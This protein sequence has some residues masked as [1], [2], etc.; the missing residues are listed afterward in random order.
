MRQF[1]E[2]E[3]IL[4]TGPFAGRPFRVSRQPWTGLWFDAIDSRRWRRH[5]LTSAQQASKTLTGST[6]PVTYHLFERQED[7]IYGIPDINMASDKWN[8]D[9][10]PSIES[11]R[12]RELLPKSGRGSKG[13]T[14]TSIQFANGRSL[15]FMVGG[16][17]DKQRAG[18]TS[19][20]LVVT[21]ADGFDVVGATSRESDKFEQLEGRLR[22][23]GDMATL[24]A[25]C[26]LSTEDG[27]TNR[28]IKGGTNSRILIRCP[29]CRAW[30]TPERQHLVGWQNAADVLQAKDEARIACPDCGELW[31]E[32]DRRTANQECTL[33]HEGQKLVGGEIQGNPK[34]TDTLGFRSTAVNNF[35]VTQGDVAAEEL[36]AS[37]DPDAERGDK[38]M[39]QFF[40]AMPAKNKNSA[41]NN[42][43][44]A[45]L[46]MRTAEWKRD[47]VPPDASSITLGIDVGLH[48]CHW[49]AIAWLPQATP[50]VLAY[51]IITHEVDGQSDER[52]I[53][54]MLR[55]FRD[56][57]A[58]RGWER[59]ERTILPSM[60]LVDSG[61]KTETVY[62]FIAESGIPFYPA[63]G[64]GQRQVAKQKDFIT[65][66]MFK[67]VMLDNGIQLVDVNA[68]EAKIF[69]HARLKTDLR[70][71]DGKPNAGA[72]T[73][74]QPSA[75]QDHRTWTHHV[76]AEQ[77][78]QE[79]IPGK[80]TVRKLVPIRE[81]NHYLDA[82]ALA[83]VAGVANGQRVV[84][85]V[86]DPTPKPAAKERPGYIP[87]RPNNYLNR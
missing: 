52:A 14:P 67:P 10:K 47:V 9:I 16:G 27:R 78:E 84:T 6:V 46:M 25:E 71:K 75:G 86:I 68:D 49:T 8:D 54:T 70:D 17:G 83:C 4:A 63:K 26:T 13:G 61:Y 37:Q 73:L 65:G 51:G 40:W 3:I 2:A 35:L 15:R 50:H 44:P 82:T 19:P 21:E 20:V 12:Y 41:V 24:Y 79:F 53:M 60:V 76:L 29:F 56:T 28:E 32:Q 87:S 64:F 85:P 80:G 72:M 30:V 59:G 39:R 66:Q 45:S 1:A 38:K 33:I 23:F 43:N 18:K 11:S 36:R 74:H 31:A 22:A 5:F 81:Q 77:E 55:E 62:T 48:R 69:V 42:F 58:R 34:R 7:V 57:V